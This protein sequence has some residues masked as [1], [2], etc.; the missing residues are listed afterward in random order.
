MFLDVILQKSKLHISG[1]KRFFSMSYL[2][3]MK[4]KFGNLKH[5]KLLTELFKEINF[6]I[7][8]NITLLRKPILAIFHHPHSLYIFIQSYVPGKGQL[9]S[10]GRFDVI[11]WTKKPT[12]FF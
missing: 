6:F 7:A 9:I 10:E 11:V 12:K 4:A 2:G 3:Q 1:L 8:Q 5:L